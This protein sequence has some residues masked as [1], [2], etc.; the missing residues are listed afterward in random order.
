ME[1]VELDL[2]VEELRN[3]FESGKTRSFEWRKAQLKSLLKLLEEK[4][5]DIFMALHKDLGKHHVE[6]FRDEVIDFC[7]ITTENSCFKTFLLM[8]FF[9][10]CVLVFR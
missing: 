1:S 3:T 2:L 10:F 9:L 7:L 6:V 4:E 5:E 8:L